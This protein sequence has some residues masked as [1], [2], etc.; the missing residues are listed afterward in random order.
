MC[1]SKPQSSNL[2]PRLGGLSVLCYAPSMFFRTISARDSKSCHE[3]RSQMMPSPYRPGIS[4]PTCGNSN[5]TREQR[6]NTVK[7]CADT[8]CENVVNSIA[9]KT[10]PNSLCRSLSIYGQFSQLNV[11]GSTLA[12]RSKSIG[13][14]QNLSETRR[15]T[16]IRSQPVMLVF[17]PIQNRRRIRLWPQITGPQ[18]LQRTWRVTSGSPRSS[19]TASLSKPTCGAVTLRFGRYSS[20][21]KMPT[22]TSSAP[23]SAPMPS[24]RS[25]L[26]KRRNRASV[27][28]RGIPAARKHAALHQCR[29]HVPYAYTVGPKTA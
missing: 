18:P 11:A 10:C 2:G 22:A 1:S 16:P 7:G 24:S 27:T 14:V 28:R 9:G 13:V 5:T 3:P 19:R 25:N 23:S 12:S 17:K 6:L 21:V 20:P 15:P 29:S 26:R 4:F 8:E